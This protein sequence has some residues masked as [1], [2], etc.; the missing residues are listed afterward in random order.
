MHEPSS[1]IPV[2][3]HDHR[4][5]SG[6]EPAML[7]AGY[8]AAPRVGTTLSSTASDGLDRRPTQRIHEGGASQA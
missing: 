8:E 7:S 2:S 3:L 1:L 6:A 4:R 5:A